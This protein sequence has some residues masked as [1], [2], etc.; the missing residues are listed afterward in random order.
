M[1]QRQ[2]EAFRLVMLRGSMTAA[3]EEM[4]TS[5]PSVSRLIAELEAA[6]GLALFVRHG[7]RIRATD[8]GTAFYREVDRSFVGLEKLGQ[9]AREI[10]QFGS[11]RLRLVAAPIMALS[12]LPAVIEDFLAEHPRVAV[13]LE[14][15]SEG[16]IQRWASSS[17][18]D[19][20]FATTPPEVVEVTSVDLYRLPGV[21]ALPAGHALAARERIVAADLRGE[22]LILPSY[23]DDTRASVDRVLRQAEALQVPAIETPYGATICALVARGLGVGVVNPL[24]IEETNP[25]RIVFRPFAPEILFRG[26]TVCP[27]WQQEKPIVQVFLAMARARMAKVRAAIASGLG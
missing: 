1:N 2:I 25:A 17:S 21:C 19:I 8:A 23:A 9:A 15:R 10:R 13:S 16:T 11:G 22:R 5:Q 18:C 26:F 6:T 20:G 12:F 7:G 3:A 4:G 14:M 27:R 24:A